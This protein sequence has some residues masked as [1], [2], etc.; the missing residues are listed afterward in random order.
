[1]MVNHTSNYEDISLENYS[2]KTNVLIQGIK[3]EINLELQLYNQKPEEIKENIY[4]TR[5]SEVD[6]HKFRVQRHLRAINEQLEGIK[7][8]YMKSEK[9]L[10][11][12]QGEFN[13]WCK[14][15]EP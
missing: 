14:S 4:G 1:M 10:I 2:L 3:D 6:E 11:D 7:H 8:N 15:R 12:G 9:F 5:K 13:D